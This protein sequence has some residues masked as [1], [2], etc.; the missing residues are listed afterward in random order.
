MNIDGPIEREFAHNG[1][2]ASLVL[3][4]GGDD[5]VDPVGGYAVRSQALF[6]RHLVAAIIDISD[7][8]DFAIMPE[9]CCGSLG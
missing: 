6:C 7:T 2:V 9:L 1:P 4:T 3:L 8:L 5:L